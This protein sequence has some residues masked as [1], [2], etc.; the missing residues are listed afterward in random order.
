MSTAR[1]ESAQDT[2]KLLP[3][4]TTAPTAKP[5]AKTDEHDGR[6]TIIIEEKLAKLSRMAIEALIHA[7]KNDIYVRAGILVRVVRVKRKSTQACLRAPGAP[8]IVPI[9]FAYLR[10]QLDLAAKWVRLGLNEILIPALPPTWVCD[11]ILDR[12][13]W[14]F[15]Q[16]E[17]VIETPT[18]RANGTVI[19]RPGYDPESG[20]LYLPQLE[21]PPVPAEP[22]LDQAAAAAVILLEP[23]RDFPFVSEDDKAACLAATLSVIG[24]SAIEGPVPMFGV[25]SPTPGTGK[26]LLVRTITLMST[27]R[28]P[29]LTTLSRREEEFR[30]RLLSIALQGVPVVA[31]DNIEGALGSPTLA[32]ALTTTE[33][34]DRLLGASKFI[35]APLTAVWFA[36]G[37]GLRFQGDVGRRVIPIDLDAKVEHPESRTG[38]K[39]APLIEYVLRE[40]S[41][42]VVAGL[43]LLR[44]YH[45]AG[46]RRHGLPRIGSFEEWD[47]L[48]RGACLWVG[49]GDPAAGRSRIRDEDDED[50]E[51]IRALYAAWV[52]Q[53]GESP[54]TVAA[55][56]KAAE[57][58]D[59]L[60]D[61]LSAFDPRA[62]VAAK[63]D[64]RVIGNRLKAIRGRVVNGHR[65][66]RAPSHAQNRVHWRVVR[67]DQDGEVS[68]DGQ[69]SR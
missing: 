63:L 17:G 58:A 68:L 44:A 37:N 29:A 66:E 8:S 4:E 39:H 25:R 24:R 56:I 32:A 5:D 2:Q 46:R 42:L 40:R 30:K 19:D 18:L 34:A 1:T 38:F 21:F 22:T 27:G 33:F 60:R 59:A 50:L 3:P 12:S 14:P 41:H 6:L 45:L 23:F 7:K 31:I 54:Q 53:F 35:R 64:A 67:S 69:V 62:S 28:E 61:A 15:P 51:T 43:T 55:A 47:D 52:E 36:T 11:T 26:G 13:E 9:T 20:L 16:L 48:I 10:L 65:L 57:A 49:V